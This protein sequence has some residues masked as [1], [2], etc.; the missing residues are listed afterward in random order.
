MNNKK[1][2]IIFCII[3]AIPI[4]LTAYTMNQVHGLDYEKHEDWMGTARRDFSM[5]SSSP[6]SAGV[7]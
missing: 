7:E 4:T 6:G 2:I 3:L 1:Y 5:Q